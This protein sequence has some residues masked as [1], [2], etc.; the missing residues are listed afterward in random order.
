MGCDT[1]LH[2]SKPA[3]RKGAVRVIIGADE[4]QNNS[5]TAVPANPGFAYTLTVTAD[6]KPAVTVDL[7]G[8]AGQ[9]FLDAGTWT[10]TVIGKKQG[11][12]VAEANP[13]SV[14]V[15]PDGD[16]AVVSVTMH[17]I[18][19]GE[20]GTFRYNIGASGAVTDVSAVL[21]PINVGSAA[22]NETDLPIASEQTLSAA[23]GYYR[24]KVR[25]VKG[26]QTLIRREVVHI[27]SHTETEKTYSLTEEDF[28]PAVVLAGTLTGGLAGYTPSGVVAYEDADCR[29][30]IGEGT[31]DGDAWTVEAEGTPETVWF[32]VRLSKGGGTAAY[33]SKPVTVSG[34]SALGKVDIVL[35]IEGYTVVFDA[36]GGTFAGG[37]DT[38]TMTAPEN[39]TVEPPEAPDSGYEFA[40]WSSAGGGFTGETPITGDTTVYAVW[41]IDTGSLQDYLADAAGGESPDNPVQLELSVLFSNENWGSILAVINSAGKYV[42]LDL[43]GSVMS[44][45]EFDPGTGNLGA[46]KVAALVLPDAA[47]SIKP[48]TYDNPPF[49]DYTSLKSI[50]GAGVKTV[51]DYAFQ[52]CE[53]L[54][55]VD[56]SAAQTI[57][58][59]AFY[60]LMRLESVSLPAATDIGDGAFVACDSL[61]SVDLPAAQTIGSDAFR[62]CRGLESVSLPASLTVIG[63]YAFSECSN[64]TIITVDP[65]NPAFTARDGMLMDKTETT[66]IVYP[67]ATGAITLPGIIDVHGG[68]FARCTS[69][70]S[71]SLP[72][73]ETIG[74]RAFS[75]CWSLVFVDMP[76][77]Q[78]IGDWAFSDCESLTD[79][80][81]PA[82]LMVI[83]NGAFRSCN[84]L[85]TIMVDPANPAFTARDGMLMDKA[86]TTLIAYPSAVGAITLPTITTIYGGAFSY[87]DSLTSV[88]LPVAETIGDYAFYGCGS[89]TDVSLPAAQTIGDRTFVY[90]GSLESVSLPATPPSIGS[91]I[92]DY[93]GSSG[94]ITVSIPSGTVPAYT[95]DWGVD[96]S[97]PAGGNTDV[98]GVRHEAVLITDAAQ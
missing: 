30:D 68:A 35:A 27:Y 23:P 38:V 80:S 37:G 84:N 56:L 31:A 95:S 1:G 25:A 50:S 49:Q 26:S 34:L 71:V 97:T 24:L 42:S 45:T 94:T 12:T 54:E 47:Q 10:L 72:V 62:D 73:V 8:D 78:T 82:S 61:V 93:T 60:S 19:N 46:D 7:E 64:L 41:R 58:D 39:G 22:Q 55:S 16:T 18:L 69:L 77:A 5:R 20:D 29:L 75:S 67:S 90:C 32:K 81:L 59:R 98:Y 87:C 79:M 13:V 11:D 53:N 17:P 15:L 63:D 74:D 36:S 14:R 57:G 66:L 83:E 65:S 2:D 85:T 44:G 86:E 9:V 92:F 43:S 52:S 70:A 51:G 96:A 4:A 76:A 21:T 40:G 91:N 48:G 28:A 3:E 6:G 33:Y 89:L 88:S